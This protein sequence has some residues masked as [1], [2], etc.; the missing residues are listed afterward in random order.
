MRAEHVAASGIKASP[1]LFFPSSATVV[2]SSFP[3]TRNRY[4]MSVFLFPK[5]KNG[6]F[7]AV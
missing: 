2:K 4:Q 1:A 5:K 6:R 3:K 7:M